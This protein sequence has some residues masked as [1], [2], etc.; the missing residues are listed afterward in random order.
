MPGGFTVRFPDGTRLVYDEPA[1]THFEG[2]HY[3]AA[4]VARAIAAG[5]LEATQRPLAE[6][7]R[8]MAVADAIRNQLGIVFPGERPEASRAAADNG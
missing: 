8:T 4:A 2:L 3:E 7:I 6:S 5:H 1:G